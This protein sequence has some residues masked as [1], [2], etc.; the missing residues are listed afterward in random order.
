MSDGK[1][2]YTRL[3]VQIFCFANHLA[4]EWNFK[5]S[6]TFYNTDSILHVIFSHFLTPVQNYEMIKEHSILEHLCTRKKGHPLRTPFFL[7]RSIIQ[8]WKLKTTYSI[9]FYFRRA[10]T[11]TTK[12]DAWCMW[13][14]QIARTIF[15][16]RNSFPFYNPDFRRK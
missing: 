2:T 3:K 5:L 12:N 4:W 9:Q 13:P 7:Q 15:R 1:E 10:T 16:N 8:I 6:R 14:S 11:M